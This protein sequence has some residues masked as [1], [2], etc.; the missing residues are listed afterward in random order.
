MRRRRDARRTRGR[1][2]SVSRGH[3][4]VFQETSFRLALRGK[5]SGNGEFLADHGGSHKT[6]EESLA[7]H[8]EE[9]E[10][11]ASWNWFDPGSS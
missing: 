6:T 8:P 9:R 10:H 5:V 4:D 3:L 2:E 7:L 11:S 1:D